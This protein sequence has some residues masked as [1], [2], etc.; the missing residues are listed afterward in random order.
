MLG[1]TPVAIVGMAVM[2]PGAGELGTYWRNLVDGVDAITDVPANRW[3][4]AVFYE[5][6]AAEGPGRADRIYCRRGGFVDE[7]AEIDALPFGI[8]P[9]AVP[10]IE[11]DQL[12]A[13]RVAAAAIADAGG[14]DRL[15]GD[16]QRV[17]VILGRGGYLSA[18]QARLA[19]RVITTT[20]LVRT[21]GELFPELSPERLDRV[22]AAFHERLG[23]EEPGSAVGVVPNF[24]ASRVANRLDLRGPAY[25]LDAACAS[26][27]VAVDHAVRELVSG[28][29]DLVLAGG[30]H[31]CHDVTL[32][33]VFAQLRAL[34][35]S[36]RIRPFDRG[37]DGLLMG[38]GTGVVALKRLSDA[39]RD[40]DRIYAVI[41]GVG[42]ASDGRSASLLNPDPQGQQRAVRQAWRAAGLDPAEPGSVGLL[43]AHGTATPAGDAAEL[44]TLGQVFGPAHGER[45]VIGSVKSMIGHAMPAAGV[46][47]MIKA[48]LA[49]YHG[50]LLPT[51]HCEDPHPALARTRFQPLDSARPWES[52]GGQRI[53]RAGVN[54]FGFGGIN[55]HV[56]LEQAPTGA[57]GAAVVTPVAEPERVLRLSA[58]SPQRL[59]ELLDADDSAI[60]ARGRA[61][62]HRRPTG[63]SRLGIV[64]PTAKR[65]ALARR[66]VANGRAWRGRNDVWFTPEPLLGGAGKLAFVFPG[67]EAEF[68]P[69]AADI[70][71]HFGLSVPGY[72]ANP[73]GGI[74][75]GD[76]GRHA[77]GVVS[78]GRLLNA[79]LRRMRITP[80]AMAGHSVGEWTAMVA[81]GM[82]TSATADELVTSF[83]PDSVRRLGLAFAVI[84]APAD[85]VL[86]A[87]EDRQE[88]V[89]SHDNAPN[90]SMVCGP[91]PIVEE[92]VRWFRARKVLGHVL[93]FQSGFHTP[94]LEPY[95]DP[96]RRIARHLE[97]LP[98]SVPVWSATTVSPYPSDA[99]DIRELFFRHLLEPVRFRPLIE[100]MYAAGFRAFIQVGTGQLG[101]LIGDTLHGKDH[102]VVP[103]ASP[104]RSGLDQLRRV[105]NALWVDGGTADTDVL[106]TRHTADRAVQRGSPMRLELGSALVSLDD[107]TSRE[108]L[109]LVERP[110]GH[111]NSGTGLSTLRQFAN[112]YPVAAELHSL[113]NNTADTA[114]T[115]IAARERSSTPPPGEIRDVLRVSV[116]T[117]PYLLDH[118]F[119]QQRRDWPDDADRFPVLPATTMIQH[120]MDFAEQAAPGRKAVAVHDVL[121]HRWVTAA[122]PTDVPV[123]VTP[124]SDSRV[125]VSFGPYARAVIELDPSYP[126]APPPPWDPEPAAERPPVL[127]A[128]Q[129]YT[130]RWMFHGPR[131]QG[132]GELIATGDAH[133][134][135]TITTPGAPGALLDN[136]G[137]ILGCWVMTS[138]TEHNVVLPVRLGGIRFFGPHPE[139]GTKIDCF[140]RI[141]SVTDSHVEADLQLV[142]DGR[143]WAELTG[144]RDRRFSTG[145]PT[146]RFPERHLLSD[147]QSGGWAL[148]F[149]GWQ[150][151][152]SRDLVIRNHLSSGEREDYERCPPGARRQFALGRIVAKDAVRQWLWTDSDDP[153]FPAEI[154]VSNAPDG[155]PLVAGLHGRIL[156][157]LTVSI[158][159]RREAAVAIARPSSGTGGPAVGI[160][161]EEVTERAGGTHEIALGAAERALLSAR[162]AATGEPEALW[163]TRFWTAKEAVAKAE[164]TGLQGRP[165]DFA[166]VAAEPSELAVEIGPR[167]YR[168]RCAQVSNPPALPIR[169]YVVAWTATEPQ[170]EEATR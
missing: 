125:A 169:T 10:G 1:N 60:L 154:K 59:A 92:F 23:P 104:H 101:S 108:L 33:S 34:S 117:M 40:A 116:E 155:R 55:A 87:L 109:P 25:T 83:D 151:L 85:R 67:L 29:C 153:I 44:A 43:E 37:A 107:R 147:P 136:A 9:N 57:V 66:V 103:A 95:L 45:P 80:D 105:A 110:T 165:R 98:P 97:T 122:P 77:V 135:G 41:R 17:G 144:W 27:L 149:E 121:F 32:W 72:P 6:D 170:D 119:I 56:V 168:V 65:L 146:E 7:F 35:P 68:D 11:P 156:P 141:T 50:V 81:S 22:R 93:P 84:G 152:A 134:R 166:V 99:D 70:A 14:Q 5:P 86:A 128:E 61:D 36:E 157:E 140:V 133:M 47:G 127:T 139:A 100:A 94:M 124:E 126:A 90:Q 106:L 158:A 123:T 53:R 42:V 58:D 102:L 21:L 163:F 15:P 89:L 111:T 114:A 48:A 8:M 88:I 162:C 148:L 113:L 164:G 49:V 26:S 91:K 160:D 3:D 30:V 150:D 137:Q 131:F 38:E 62:D 71:E 167:R 96:V 132:V 51:L 75:V 46:A 12:I 24:V 31:H 13:L 118:G 2:L 129:L 39:E 79:A 115:L 54:A 130:G 73:D 52:I 78:L 4:S 16:R 138:L 19:Q 145:P 76:V 142:A 20:Q 69:R 18:G 63:G 82:C 64:D 112:R 159:H 28:R 74:L 143:V 120:M 161:I